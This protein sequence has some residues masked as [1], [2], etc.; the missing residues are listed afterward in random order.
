MCILPLNIF[1][2]SGIIFMYSI[3]YKI[4]NT[5]RHANL[6]MRLIILG[7]I[8]FIVITIIPITELSVDIRLVITF[9][10]VL[11]YSIL[12]LMSASFRAFRDVSCNYFC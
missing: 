12:D 9:L 2:Y 5:K 6:L 4:M 8:V 10:V 1:D 3:I 7:V 11:T